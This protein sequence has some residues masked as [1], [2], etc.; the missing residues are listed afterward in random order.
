MAIFP[1]LQ[2]KKVT[3][4][5][6]NGFLYLSLL[7]WSFFLFSTFFERLQ[8]KQQ[9]HL[10][11]ESSKTN[12]VWRGKREKMERAF[13]PPPPPPPSLSERITPSLWQKEQ[14]GNKKNS[15]SNM[16]PKRTNLQHV[17]SKIFFQF[18]FP[19]KIPNENKD[20]IFEFCILDLAEWRGS[21]TPHS[22]TVNL[23]RN[24]KN[25]TDWY[26][27]EVENGCGNRRWVCVV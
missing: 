1:L 25:S 14:K 2:K 21:F 4:R 19:N 7:G 26:L 15:N 10:Q 9:Q 8:K 3:L 22:A 11:K 17:A 13:P 6:S 23:R 27:E 12:Q 5:R 20:R 16:E 18:R 24:L